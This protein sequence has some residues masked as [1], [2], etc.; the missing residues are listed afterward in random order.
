MT[1]SSEQTRAQPYPWDMTGTI[2]SNQVGRY[3]KVGLIQKSNEGFIF[4]DVAVL[5]R[6]FVIAL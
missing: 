5:Y 4:R 3:S 2:C 6:Q 1:Q